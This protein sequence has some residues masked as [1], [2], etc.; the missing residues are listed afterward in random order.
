MGKANGFIVRLSQAR[1]KIFHEALHE[2]GFFAEAVNKFDHSRSLPL[3]CFIVNSDGIITHIARGRR[4]MSAGTAQSRLNVE[5]ITPL[6]TMLTVS[7][8]IEGVPNRNRKPVE[9]RFLNG[10]LLTPRAFEEVIDLVALLAQE[11]K[12]SL[13]RFS[14]NTRQRV[15]AL[16]SGTRDTLGYQKE[17][18]ATA[19]NMAGMDRAPLAQWTL[20]SDGEPKSFL[21]V[22]RP[23]FTGGSKDRIFWS[24]GKE[25]TIE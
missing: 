3:I 13:D 12:S 21:E 20:E 14:K 17:S 11:T 8:I 22:N 24:Y 6:T 10:G 19:L 18:V 23:G 5:D 9:N 15:A 2:R 7:D 25:S 16:S 4:G 1:E